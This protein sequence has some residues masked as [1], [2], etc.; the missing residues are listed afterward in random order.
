[1]IVGCPKEIKTQEHRAGLVPTSV[2]ELAT[3]GHK[4][5]VQSRTGEGLNFSDQ[6]Y[7]DAGAEIRETA[8]EIFDEAELII[9]VKEPQPQECK[10]LRE[11]QILFTYLHLA[12]DPV[13]TKALMDSG[14]VAIA[15]E[16]VIGPNGHGLPLLAPM[17]EIAGRLSVQVGAYYLQKHMGGNGR[18]ISGVP[19]VK[20]AKVLVLGGGVSGFNAAQMAVGLGAN[21]MIL[22]RN[23][24]RMRF[25]DDHFKGRATVL[26]SNMGTVEDEIE[27]SDLVIGAVLIPGA[28]APRLVSQAMFPSMIPG[29][30]MVDISIDQGGCFETSKATTHNDPV[31][32]VD[33]IVHYCVANMPGAVPLTSTLALNHAVLPYLLNLADKGWKNALTDVPGFMHGLNICHGKITHENVAGSLDLSYDPAQ[34]SIA[35]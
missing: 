12:A 22:E 35:A 14:C 34:D 10:M 31:Y 25:L 21:V 9:K 8:K 24:D 4:V 26:Y 20:P 7:I 28:S 5:I 13:Q 15:Y 19:G 17:S 32:M 33:D 27:T 23:H 1:M 3:H 30:V 16:T 2:R 18:L 11:G 29:T 6:D